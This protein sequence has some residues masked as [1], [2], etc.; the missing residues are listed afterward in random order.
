MYTRSQ[1]WRELR[2]I[3]AISTPTIQ[4]SSLIYELY[5]RGDQSVFNVPC[6]KCGKYQ[7]LI[8]NSDLQ[9]G[10]KW[11]YKKQHID[12]KKLVYVCKHCG[13]SFNEFD[14]YD[15]NNAGKYISDAIAVKPTIR[16]F[17]VNALYS[18]LKSWIDIA[19]EY[20]EQVADMALQQS[21]TNLIMGWPYK[22]AGSRPESKVVMERTASSKYKRRQIP[23]GVL[24]LTIG[25]DMQ[26]GKRMYE[27]YS[28][29]QLEAAIKQAKLEKKVENFPRIELEVCGH[30]SKYRT[31]SIDYLVFEGKLDN[32]FSGAWEKLAKY[33]IGGGFVYNRILDGREFR[34]VI[35]L[36]DSGTKH[37]WVF[38]F[39]DRWANTFASK[40][41][42]DT[43]GQKKEK[44]DQQTKNDFR[45]YRRA[46]MADGNIIFEIGTNF[47]KRVIYN[48]LKKERADVGDNPAAFCDFPRDYNERYF[49]ML[50]AEE[51]RADGSFHAGGRRNEALDCRVLNMCASDIYLDREVLAQRD[52][53]RDKMIKNKQPVNQYLLDR[54]DRG[55]IVENIE[56]G[57][58][59]DIR[60]L[61]KA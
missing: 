13:K 53:V 45:R 42:S 47:Y 59:Q 4:D 46:R 27:N 58:L 21:F 7:Q 1:A 24:Y 14:K 39:I 32:P 61:K 41:F 17:H 37:E 20:D 30:G 16:S 8:V 57:V 19:Y 60:N 48:A 56:R 50:T 51:K 43:P 40:G 28:E 54:I 55:Y 23:W 11:T 44:G 15:F 22:Q 6:V 34:P 2:K 52:R 9:Y 35:V 36:I 49:K 29:R 31:W 33:E 18:P 5:L 38:G 3:L 26:E 12:E 10:L 25:I